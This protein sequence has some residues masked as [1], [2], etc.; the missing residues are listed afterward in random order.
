MAEMHRTINPIL[1]SVSLALDSDSMLV[2]NFRIVVEP[3]WGLYLST[4][5][6]KSSPVALS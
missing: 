1:A 5:D 4:K 6:G 2:I 3:S